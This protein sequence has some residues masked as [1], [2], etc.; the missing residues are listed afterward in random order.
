MTAEERSAFAEKCKGIGNRGFQVVAKPWC[1]GYHHHSLQ[2][3]NRY[4]R[5]FTMD[6]EILG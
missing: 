3:T 4:I 5:Y 6:M 1:R 2:D